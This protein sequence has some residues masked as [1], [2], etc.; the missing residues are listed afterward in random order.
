M[1]LHIELMRSTIDRY[2]TAYQPE[3][4][5]WSGVEMVSHPTPSGCELSKP[6][7]SDERQWP[8]A[9]TAKRE[10]EAVLPKPQFI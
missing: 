4:G 7:D 1:S 6:S 10:F 9:T 5:Q 2:V 8:D 3:N